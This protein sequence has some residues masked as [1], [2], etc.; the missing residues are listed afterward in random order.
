[1]T[2]PVGTGEPATPATVAASLTDAPGCTLVA[3]VEAWVERV[4]VAWRRVSI[5]LPVATPRLPPLVVK[6][7]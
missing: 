2:V 7:R 3:L 6:A 4:A 1:M 5:W